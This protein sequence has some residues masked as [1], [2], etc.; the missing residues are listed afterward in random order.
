M[1]PGFGLFVSQGP[2]GNF[3]VKV[4]YTR[5][6]LLDLRMCIH[7]GPP[8]AS[9]LEDLVEKGDVE[10]IQGTSRVD[11]LLEVEGAGQGLG[12]QMIAR[13]EK[14]ITSENK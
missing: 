13:T 7:G 14:P 1:R 5:D 2:L 12:A 6:D 9:I 11:L 8:E 3:A 10:L 4:G